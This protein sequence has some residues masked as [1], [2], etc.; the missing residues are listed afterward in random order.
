MASTEDTDDLYADLYADTGAQDID[1][2]P[3]SGGGLTEDG[4]EDDLIMYNDDTTTQPAAS[5]SNLP[6]KP[7]FIPPASGKSTSFIPPPPA[8]AAG[9]A[10]ASSSSSKQPP[11]GVNPGQQSNGSAHTSQQGAGQSTGDA[12]AKPE[13]GDGSGAEKTLLPHE[14]PEEGK[15][16]V[17]GLNWDTTDGNYHAFASAPQG[18]RN[19]FSQFGEVGHCTIM[20]DAATGRS[21]CFAFLTFVDPK[22]VNTVM[23]REHFLDGKVIDPKR[24]I[25]RPEQNV[26]RSQKVFVG[27]LPQSVTPQSFRAYFEQFGAVIESNCMMDKE[28]GN[29]RG[30]GFITFQDETSVQHVLNIQPLNFEGKMVEVKRA[31]TRS[32]A[33]NAR[34][35]GGG[36]A[37]G[38]R[39]D[40]GRGGG[41]GMGMGGMGGMGAMGGGGMG[42]MAGM[43]GMGGA[44]GAQGMMNPMMNPMAAMGMMGGSGA[45]GAAGGGGGGGGGGFDPQAIAR[46][47]QQMGWGSAN[48]NPQM[49]WQ[50]M[51]ASLGGMG[52]MAGMDMGMGGM[53]MGM[54]GMGSGMGGGMGGMGMGGMSNGGASNGVGWGSQ[55]GRGG[56]GGGGG[57]GNAGGGYRRDQPRGS[58]QPPGSA[59]L[60]SRPMSG[61]PPSSGATGG[62]GHAGSY[63]RDHSRERSPMRNR[64]DSRDAHRRER[65]PQRGGSGRNYDSGQQQRG[66]R[67]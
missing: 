17:G 60:P 23:V 10:A 31:Q 1:G 2:N 39:F 59:G 5:D 12:A 67:F 48:W 53:G 18:L 13:K 22:A 14:M 3:T 15:M 61:S 37:G 43:A 45:A 7:S 65:S 26:S 40:G 51:T 29:P 28:T 47:Y 11:Q 24:A 38:A 32:D 44:G 30:F 21:R 16:F 64:S 55:G 9:A 62:G 57:G 19:Y 52:G 34:G 46:M 8:A 58:L 20:R 35:I 4:D 41:G 50:Q 33:N 49:A 54:Q 56:G 6:S 66:Q 63:G 42:G 36:G 25:P 27:G